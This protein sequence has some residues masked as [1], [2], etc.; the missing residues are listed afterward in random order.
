MAAKVGKDDVVIRLPDGN[1]YAVPQARLEEFRLSNESVDDLIKSAAPPFTPTPTAAA[2]VSAAPLAAVA[3]FP[4]GLPPVVGTPV[5]HVLGP[6]PVGTPF[7]PGP[8]LGQPAALGTPGLPAAPL[9]VGG[10]APVLVG[11][12]PISGPHIIYVP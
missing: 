8:S 10:R 2:M 5:A 9:G 7:P 4:V 11:P 6:V 3:P 1:H 12:S